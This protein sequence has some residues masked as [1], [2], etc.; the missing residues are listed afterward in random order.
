M[1]ENP[2][3]NIQID[4]KYISKRAKTESID[5]KAGLCFI[6]YEYSDDANGYIPIKY[7]SAIMNLNTQTHLG[8][9]LESM[10]QWTLISKKPTISDQYKSIIGRYTEN[11]FKMISLGKIIGANKLKDTTGDNYALPII[12]KRH[13][14]I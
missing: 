8:L 9:L 12:F 2:D 3:L 10:Y 13:P 5:Y 11:Y 4:K 14:L 7:C 6:D 1:S